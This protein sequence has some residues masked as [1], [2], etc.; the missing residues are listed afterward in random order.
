MARTL[1]G[2]GSPAFAAP[3]AAVSGEVTLGADCSLWHNT[4]LRGD[5]A[6][7][8]VGARS[9][10]QD[11]AVLHVETTH[12]CV[13]G[14]DVTV[15]H[16]A[17][18]HGCRIGDRCLIGMGAIILN[19][20]EIG[21]ECIVGAGALITE[22]KKIPPRSLVLGMPAKVVRSVGDDEVRKILENAASYL[23]LARLAAAESAEAGR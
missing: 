2:A 4:T 16:G 17:I 12:P 1:D 15:G 22:G 14:D 11:G 13:V 7:I 18:V 19:G 10:V 8:F 5:L 21:D 20:A 6:P 9:N 3:S 23:R